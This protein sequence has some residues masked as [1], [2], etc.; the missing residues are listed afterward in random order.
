MKEIFEKVLFFKKFSVL[1][2]RENCLE[3]ICVLEVI[4]SNVIFLYY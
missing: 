2:T 3:S 4:K 1:L